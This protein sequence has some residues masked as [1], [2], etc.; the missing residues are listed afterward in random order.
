MALTP[1][2]LPEL[3]RAVYDLA[4]H[5]GVRF[6]QFDVI[7]MT[8]AK[9]TKVD[10]FY[11]AEFVGDD[12]VHYHHQYDGDTFDLPG[13]LRVQP[14]QVA[15][16]VRT[17]R[18]PYLYSSD[19]G[20]LLHAGQ[21]FG[22]M[23]KTSRDAVVC[24]VFDDGAH[25]RHRRVQGLISMQTYTPNT[26][27]ST[28]VAALEYLAEAFGAQVAHEERGAE[29]SRRLMAGSSMLQGQRPTEDIL[30]EA[31][32]ALNGLHIRLDKS[33][34][35]SRKRGYDVEADLR[36][37][38]RETERLQ[39]DL[40]A[41][42]LYRRRV[43]AEIL[44]SLTPR[45]REVVKLLADLTEGPGGTPSNAELAS[46]MNIAESTIKTH[47][48]AA[49]RAFGV[50]DRAHVAAAVRRLTGHQVYDGR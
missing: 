16:W 48:N 2:V 12:N 3:E 1:D 42:E 27:D 19:Q 21:R 24:P 10:A 6:E 46:R 4:R 26:Y 29:R 31:L 37:L 14:G 11:V 8:M 13:S 33:L 35:N 49:L 22:K 40:W 36:A 47:M 34:S 18:R 30:G 17:S 45:Q 44:A 23:D 38:K 7:R 32:V 9:I 25:R 15:H 5:R 39:S 50:A 43:V 20:R 41:S 28:A